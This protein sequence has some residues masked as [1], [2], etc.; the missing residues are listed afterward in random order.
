M[1]REIVYDYTATNLDNGLIALFLI[2]FNDTY[3]ISSR[4]VYF[5]RIYAIGLRLG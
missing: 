5:T 4:V 2:Y 1:Y 3:W